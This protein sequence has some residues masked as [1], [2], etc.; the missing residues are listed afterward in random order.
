M[1]GEIEDLDHVKRRTWG[2]DYIYEE[3]ETV[4]PKGV[5]QQAIEEARKRE[6]RVRR[7]QAQRYEFLAPNVAWSEDF[8]EV[9]PEGKVLR[10]QDDFSRLA[11]GGEHRREWTGADVSRFLDA[12]FRRYGR[13]YFFKHDLGGEFRDGIFQAFLRGNQVIAFPNPP[14]C[15]TYNGKMERQNGAVRFWLAR[16]V[17]DRPALED[18]LREIRLSQL[19]NNHDRRKEVLGD[20][21]PQEAQSSTPQIQVDRGEL[22]AEWDRLKEKLVKE[23]YVDDPS[24][25][26]GRRVTTER[27]G[28]LMAMRIASLVL[29]KKYRMFRY[30]VG[31]EAPEQVT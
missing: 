20:R 21:T 24:D 30:T 8:I 15:P 16:A 19:D 6:N 28:E 2:T 10:V 23:R 17:D 3:Y 13:P 22:Y 31:P 11:L 4:I 18:V 26:A 14:Y 5:I 12:G 1:L 7:A 27:R 9:K 29:L 25:P